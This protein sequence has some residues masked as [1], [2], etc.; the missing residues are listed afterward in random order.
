MSFAGASGIIGAP[1]LGEPKPV[2]G[3]STV[4]GAL[5]MV[6]A[7]WG[8]Y[9]PGR[10]DAFGSR[11]L[12]VCALSLVEYWAVHPV[13]AIVPPMSNCTPVWKDASTQAVP[14]AS[15]LK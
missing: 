15:P 3:I 1:P 7:T 10:P 5:V 2:N 12:S 6:R 11:V 13:P 14:A 4:V 9:E 8:A